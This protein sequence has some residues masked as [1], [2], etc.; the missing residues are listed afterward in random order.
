MTNRRILQ[1]WERNRTEAGTA[2]RRNEELC[3]LGS[4]GRP[5][6]GGGSKTG[7]REVAGPQPEVRARHR[8]HSSGSLTVGDRPIEKSAERFDEER[9]CSRVP[10]SRNV[11]N[12]AQSFQPRLAVSPP[13]LP[14]SPPPVLPTFLPPFLTRLLIIRSHVSVPDPETSGRYS[15]PLFARL[16]DSTAD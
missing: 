9:V 5:I 15:P 4:L 10:C 12:R 3:A 14:H 16:E 13:S 6:P 11:H 2:T 8:R 7:I 1:A